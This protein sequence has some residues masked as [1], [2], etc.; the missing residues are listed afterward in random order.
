MTKAEL[1][2]EI[3]M[4]GEF[5]YAEGEHK[6]VDGV[7]MHYSRK[8]VPD[9]GQVTHISLAK[10]A[11]MDWLSVRRAVVNG[12]DVVQMTR[13]IGYYSRLSNWNPSKIGELKDRHKGDYG[14]S[15][16]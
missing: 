9:P 7:F 12:R 2:A 6:G 4:D 16:T 13:I 5:D 10:L 8:D 11:D 1:I 3:D 14:V 15:V